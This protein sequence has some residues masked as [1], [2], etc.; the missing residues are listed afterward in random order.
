MTSSVSET[1][2]CL[3]ELLQTHETMSQKIYDD[4]SKGNSAEEAQEAAQ[5][6]LAKVDAMAKKVVDVGGFNDT[7]IIENTLFAIRSHCEA[8]EIETLGNSI[9]SLLL[10]LEGKVLI[11]IIEI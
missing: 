5:V 11:D 1:C 2:Q 4:L 6:L 3:R 8:W 7:A 10:K 9:T